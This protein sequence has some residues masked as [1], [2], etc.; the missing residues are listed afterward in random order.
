MESPHGSHP[1]R[2][3][4]VF[5]WDRR[6]PRLHSPLPTTSA[7]IF[8]LNLDES[9]ITVAVIRSMS[10]KLP[11]PSP[12]RFSLGPQASPPASTQ[13]SARRQTSV[14][15]TPW[16][17]YFFPFHS[18]R[19]DPPQRFLT[20]PRPEAHAVHFPHAHSSPFLHR[21]KSKNMQARTPALPGKAVT[22]QPPPPISCLGCFLLKGH[23]FVSDEAPTPCPGCFSSSPAPP[24][25]P[26]FPGSAGVPA[27]IYPGQRQ[28]PNIRLTN[29]VVSLF[30]SIPFVA[31]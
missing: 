8:I 6:R 22:T 1:S 3:R 27:C 20:S 5:P 23:K 12:R 31:M 7:E 2:A 16:C 9:P 30:L 26:F 10:V 28:T 19:C 24:H 11:V 18:L 21:P 25:T 17:L 15:P 13:V 14:S 4:G 29:P